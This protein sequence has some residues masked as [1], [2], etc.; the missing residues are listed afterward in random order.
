MA[1]KTLNKTDQPKRFTTD[2]KGLGDDDFIVSK[3]DK[4]G[5]ITYVNQIFARLA[6]YPSADLIGANHNLIRHPEMPRV[7]FKIA[8]ERIQKKQEFFGLIKNLCADGGY[9]WVYAYITADTDDKG[10]II[11][12]TSIR[13]KSPQSAIDT[14]VPIYKRLVD[15][16]AHGDIQASQKLLDAILAEKGVGYDEFI[17]GLQ[18][19]IRV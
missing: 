10:E 11:G 3:T 9:Y 1:K 13:R 5:K 16:E 6:G 19:D 18:K 17:I 15:A 8:W 2:E 7:A 12:Y 14:I 4:Y